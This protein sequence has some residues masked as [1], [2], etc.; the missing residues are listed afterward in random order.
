M[1]PSQQ[2]AQLAQLQA[3][4]QQLQSQSQPQTQA[5]PNAQPNPTWNPFQQQM[6][7]PQPSQPLHAVMNTMLSWFMQAQANTQPPL[8]SSAPTAQ[9]PTP[10]PQ[11][12]TAT[13]QPLPF[14]DEDL[15][16][17]IAEKTTQGMTYKSAIESLHLVRNVL[18]LSRVSVLLYR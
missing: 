14:N 9:Q 4:I 11:D 5:Q 2:S 6:Q 3:H 13:V 12:N 17:V 1:D 18:W 8:Q 10:A 15:A 7:Q 16:K